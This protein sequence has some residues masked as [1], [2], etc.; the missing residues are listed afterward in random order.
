MG[1]GFALG[2]AA[3]AWSRPSSK[4]THRQALV[5][6]VSCGACFTLCLDT[7]LQRLRSSALSVFSLGMVHLVD[8]WTALR[9]RNPYSRTWL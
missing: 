2:C 8:S 1:R 4:A 5:E 9:T 6:R 7:C 3:V